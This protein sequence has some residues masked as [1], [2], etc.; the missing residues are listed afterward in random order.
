M[1]IAINT[2]SG[3]GPAIATTSNAINNSGTAMS[4]S[5]ERFIE[6]LIRAG[7]TE[8]IVPSRLPKSS[9]SAGA[10]TPTEAFWGL[11]EPALWASGTAR[12][13]SDRDQV[14]ATG[15]W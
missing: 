10:P 7:T 6:K 13:I 15:T 3:P 11:T 1:E 4:T 9:A 2:L 14:I 12:V 5:T 8:P